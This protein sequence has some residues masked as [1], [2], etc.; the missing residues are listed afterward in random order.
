MS[1]F[2]VEENALLKVKDMVKD[3]NKSVII[4]DSFIYRIYKKKLYKLF[5]NPSISS[6][7]SVTS[8][9]VNYLLIEA[10]ENNKNF[11]HLQKYLEK[12]IEFE[13]D[14][15][16]L[17]IGIGGGIILDI[18][19][20]IASIYQRGI[21]FISIPTTLLSMCDASFGG[22]NGMNFGSFKN[23]IGSIYHP[24]HL[25]IDPTF[26][27]TLSEQ[28]FIY[29]LSEVIKHAIIEPSF[30]VYLQNNR[31]LILNKDMH[32]LKEMI[33]QSLTIKNA[34]ILNDVFDKN[35]K[36]AILNFGHT[37]G[38]ALESFFNF[39]SLHHGKAVSM[40]MVF[41]AYLSFKMGY[42]DK[43]HVF[44]II[45]L[46][47]TFHQDLNRLE[48]CSTRLV[49]LIK[50]DKKG[51]KGKIN[52]VLIKEFGNLFVCKNIDENYLYNTIL[53]VKELL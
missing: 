37:F 27:N 53:E 40:G 45:D 22:K 5:S 3:Y 12:L 46:L 33:R 49:E 8:D 17:L 6:E 28:H 41:E 44:K 38:H 25:I 18:V 24:K 50:K 42:T 26:L 32:T 11:T 20:F 9:S 19:G 35:D 31:D 30:M 15:N 47:Q 10:S 7:I 51:S 34:I 1:D 23:Y 52:C 36:R 4:C 48:F 43:I 21:D 13:A 16:S 39:S 14:K 29:G 2:I